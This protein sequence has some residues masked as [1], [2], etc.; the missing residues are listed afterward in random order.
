VAGSSLGLDRGSNDL[1]D[2]GC[3]NGCRRTR[4]VPPLQPRDEGL[5]LGFSVRRAPR[6]STLLLASAKCDLGHAFFEFRVLKRHG[7]V[8]C[9]C[10]GCAPVSFWFM[11]SRHGTLGLLPPARP[12]RSRISWW[13]FRS[14]R[15]CSVS[16]QS[17]W[18]ERDWMGLNPKQLKLL[19]NFFQS[20]PIHVYWE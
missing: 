19:H 13:V 10:R 9:R 16:S 14:L 15:A 12:R 6:T 11:T 8:S 20:H 1:H 3:T 4:L 5:G 7:I 2:V 18:I 17:M